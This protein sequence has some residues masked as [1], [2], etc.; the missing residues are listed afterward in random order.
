MHKSHIRT[1]AATS[2]WLVAKIAPVQ[3]L[4]QVVSS[5]TVA[6]RKLLIWTCSGWVVIYCIDMLSFLIVSSQG[7]HEAPQIW[8]ILENNFQK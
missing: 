7:M 2:L 1:D 5:Y 3:L 6:A 8:K 4:H